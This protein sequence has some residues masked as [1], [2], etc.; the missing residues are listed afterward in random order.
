VGRSTMRRRYGRRGLLLLAL[1]FVLLPF[2]GSE[3]V[4]AVTINCPSGFNCA[5]DESGPNDVP[6]QKDLNLQGVN[7]SGLPTSIDVLWNWDEVGISGG[8]TL[9][10]CALFDTDK[11]GDANFAV[12]ATAGGNPAAN[13]TTTVFTCGDSRVDRCSS[14]INTVPGASSTCTV[15]SPSA[16]D[17]WDGTGKNRGDSFPNDARATCHIVLADVGASSAKLINVC[18]YPSSQP[19]SDPSDCVLVPRDAFLTI[20]KIANGNAGTFPFTLD[21]GTTP[22]FTATFTSGGTQSSDVIPIRSDINHSVAEQLPSSGGWSLTSAICSGAGGNNG[23]LS[24]TTISGI[25]P[26][27][28]DNITCTFTNAQAPSLTLTKTADAASVSAGSTIGFTV[29]LS[30]G[31]GAGT[32]TGAEINDNLPGGTVGTVTWAESPDNANC[33]I[34]GSAG[35]QVLHCGPVSVAPGGSISVHVSATTSAANCGVYNNSATFTTT[36]NGTGSASASITCKKPSLTLSKTADAASVSAGSPIGFT[37]T[38]ANAAGAGNATGASISDPLPVGS[39][40]TWTIASQSPAGA[41]ALAADARPGQTLSCGPRSVNAGTSIT[42]HVTSP[43]TAN[44]CATY[45]NTANFTSTNDASGSKSASTTVNCPAVT[46]K[47]KADLASVSAGTS[48]G[49]TVTVCNGSLSTGSCVASAGTGTATGVEVN[50][51]LPGGNDINWSTSSANCTVSIGSPQQLHCGPVSLAAGSFITAHVT[52]PTTGNSC[53]TYDN[54]AS[55]TSTN[56]G[57]GSDS[58]STTVN[59][60]NLTLTKTADAASVSAGSPIGFTVTLANA[61]GAGTATGATISDPL[62]VGNGITWTI[63]SQSPAGACSLVADARPGQTLSCGPRSLNAGASITAHVTSPTT[64]ANCGGAFD[65]TASFTSTNDGSGSDSDSTGVTCPTIGFTSTQQLT[66]QD[67]ATVTPAS[68]SGPTPS[69]SAL[70]ELFP[71]SDSN[72]TGT[73]SFFETVTLDGQGSAQAP[74]IKPPFVASLPGTWRWH[75]HYSG[76]GNYLGSDSV[77]GAESFTIVNA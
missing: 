20:T 23:T 1:V 21:A 72:C 35:S 39:D 28:D 16:T 43:T 15:A 76:D 27:P 45:D 47:K 37:V 34:T 29:T 18:S 8:N 58:D 7:S 50:D 26:N 10:A 12:C 3:Q 31:S 51:T 38:L 40:I 52:S 55:F 5:V 41:C 68:G 44:S 66:A 75:V 70:F 32:A 33:A 59:C 17:P 2:V 30:N 64:V 77:C 69:G 67:S 71:P 62:P 36:N 6:G 42:V 25:D 56:N 61:P 4:G 73:P 11:D 74:A 53:G 57:S 60:P 49:F 48:I 46:I 22:V 13:P 24:G 14:Q 65:N 63:A 19:N 54:T 9:D